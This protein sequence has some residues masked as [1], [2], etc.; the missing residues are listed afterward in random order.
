MFPLLILLIG[1]QTG[2]RNGRK[3]GRRSEEQMTG[4]SEKGRAYAQPANMV[5]EGKKI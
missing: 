4:R 1:W 3:T 5:E 2:G